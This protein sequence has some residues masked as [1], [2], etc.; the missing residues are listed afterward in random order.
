MI[1][2][3]THQIETPPP[4]LCTCMYR[5]CDAQHNAALTTYVNSLNWDSLFSKFGFGWQDEVQRKI[6]QRM[7][8]NIIE[9]EHKGISWFSMGTKVVPETNLVSV[10][11]N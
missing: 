4:S 5:M 3:Y 6:F 10:L 11:P 9:H 1:T 7:L 8:F 2:P